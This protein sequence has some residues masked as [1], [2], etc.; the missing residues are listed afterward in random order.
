MVTALPCRTPPPAPDNPRTG[1]TRAGRRGSV[2][3]G[4]RG[5][6]T[7]LW[8]EQ[9]FE[10]AGAVFSLSHLNKTGPSAGEGEQPTMADSIGDSLDQ[11]LEGRIIGDGRTTFQIVGMCVDPAHQRKRCFR[12][13]V[14][15]R[16]LVGSRGSRGR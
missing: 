11:E 12:M 1:R 2:S 4:I 14:R 3:P 16:R 6:Q 8:A 9:Q 13:R 10:E 15:G 5:T 7:A